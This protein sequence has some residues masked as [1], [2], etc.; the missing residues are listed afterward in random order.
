MEN[1]EI[2][3]SE[4][5]KPQNNIQN[6][7]KDKFDTEEQHLLKETDSPKRDNNNMLSFNALNNIKKKL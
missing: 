6:T 5:K 3:E 7:I 1:I 4:P 2:I